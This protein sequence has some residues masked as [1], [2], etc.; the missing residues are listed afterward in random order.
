MIIEEMS[1]GE[2]LKLHED[3]VKKGFEC[4]QSFDASEVFG[5]YLKRG[6]SVRY[7]WKGKMLPEMER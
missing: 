2:F 6:D 7:V 1:E 3:L 5:L 4:M